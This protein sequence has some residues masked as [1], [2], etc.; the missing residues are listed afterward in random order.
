MI[1]GTMDSKIPLTFNCRFEF[2][3]HNYEHEAL[4]TRR[5]E[6][7]MKDLNDEETRP[8]LLQILNISLKQAL[9]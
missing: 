7:T 3:D 5:K 4:I 6:V 1:W 8:Q 9:K 2:K